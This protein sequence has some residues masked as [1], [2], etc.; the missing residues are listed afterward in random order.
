MI[1]LSGK[2]VME[3]CQRKLSG[4]GRRSK[5]M[6]EMDE[7]RRKNAQKNRQSK[8]GSKS[9]IKA[10]QESLPESGILGGQY[11]G[12][13]RI[14][15]INNSNYRYYDYD[16][17][18]FYFYSFDFYFIYAIIWSVSCPST[19]ITHVVLVVVVFSS[20]KGLP[21]VAKYINQRGIQWL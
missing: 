12:G 18:S 19:F 1:I 11:C 2:I 10:E 7:L 14:K 21:S 15:R 13:S 16:Y 4:S 9:L 8:S 17:T 5:E 6:E 3:N 20:N